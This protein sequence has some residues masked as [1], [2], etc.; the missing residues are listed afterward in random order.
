MACCVQA[1]VVD[2]QNYLTVTVPTPG[3][4]VGY[5][6]VD[7]QWFHRCATNEWTSATLDGTTLTVRAPTTQAIAVKQMRW[8]Q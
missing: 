1:L 2:D 7:D 5:E 3:E 8:N 6:F 4:L